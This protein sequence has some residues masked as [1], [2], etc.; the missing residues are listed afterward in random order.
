[1]NNLENIKLGIDA[2]IKLNGYTRASFA[3]KHSIDKSAFNCLKY[4]YVTDMSIS[5]QECI[6]KDIM[7]K[8]GITL[9]DL[10]ISIKKVSELERLSQIEQLEYKEL[11]NSRDSERINPF[12][13]E[14]ELLWS[15]YP[16]LSFGQLIGMLSDEIG[17]DSSYAEDNKWID[18]VK[19]KID[20]GINR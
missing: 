14:V 2:Y 5:E 19:E 15:M 18:V 1:M 16:D 7:D 13:K 20:Y 4:G 10:D 3:K 11:M 12:L 8:E 17:E 9:E 6:L